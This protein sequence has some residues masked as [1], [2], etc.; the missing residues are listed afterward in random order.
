ML[1]EQAEAGERKGH[2]ERDRVAPPVR[3][4]L[5]EDEGLFPL[6]TPGATHSAHLV[7]E[8]LSFV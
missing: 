2:D 7:S 4:W 1:L 8:L 5:E 3:E 6:L